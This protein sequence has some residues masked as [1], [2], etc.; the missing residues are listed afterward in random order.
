MKKITYDGQD[1]Y[2]LTEDQ[3]KIVDRILK[4]LP[5]IEDELH[6]Y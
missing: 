6:E 2:F 4:N 3:A 1:G 5:T